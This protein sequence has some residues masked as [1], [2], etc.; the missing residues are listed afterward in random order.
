LFSHH[1]PVLQLALA[2]H[3]HHLVKKDPSVLEELEELA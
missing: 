2:H 1:L 3:H